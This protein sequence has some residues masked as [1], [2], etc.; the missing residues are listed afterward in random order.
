M[1]KRKPSQKQQNI[2]SE[3]KKVRAKILKRIRSLEKRGYNI[4]LT[5]PKVPKTKTEASIRNLEKITLERLYKR[6]TYH[7]F[8]SYG[9]EVSGVK[10]RELERKQ[11]AEKAKET[12]KRKRKR[13]RKKK[14]KPTFDESFFSRNT[15]NVWYAQVQA[16]INGRFASALLKWMDRLIADN[17]VNDV[18]KMLNDGEAVGVVFTFDVAYDSVSFN[19]Y[20]SE[21]IQYLPDQ[22]KLYYEDMEEY[23]EEL[24]RWAGLA[25]EEE[26]FFNE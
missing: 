22:G 3:Y 2:N 23:K 1:G 13:K 19:R 18:A 4:E 7:G 14:D 6:S 21:L 26:E 15:I 16:C 5:I 17:G 8:A 11:S 12:R 9:E 24:V 10:G 20:T 25:E